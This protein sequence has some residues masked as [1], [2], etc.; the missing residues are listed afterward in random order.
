MCFLVFVVDLNLF[1]ANPLCS[2]SLCA[3]ADS[4]DQREDADGSGH[5]V[6]RSQEPTQQMAETSGLH[7]RAGLQQGLAQ[8]SGPGW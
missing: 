6:R 4:V 7:G 8:Q 1:L 5:V 3:S 2:L